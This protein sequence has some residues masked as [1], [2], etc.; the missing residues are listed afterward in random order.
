[1]NNQHDIKFIIE[2]TGNEKGESSSSENK[3]CEQLLENV[4]EVNFLETKFLKRT[5]S[6]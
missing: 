2:P 5:Y 6:R 1:M 3:E 4:F